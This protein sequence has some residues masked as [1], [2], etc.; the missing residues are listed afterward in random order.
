MPN[1]PYEFAGKQCDLYLVNQE[2]SEREATY[3]LS[4]IVKSKERKFDSYE[5]AYVDGL[6]AF[7]KANDDGNPFF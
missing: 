6:N 3:P 5:K 1:M 7:L 2:R 4:A